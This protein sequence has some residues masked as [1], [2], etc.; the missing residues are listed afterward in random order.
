MHRS[1]SILAAILILALGC[2][3]SPTTE[4]T[5][6]DAGGLA[7]FLSAEEKRYSQLDEEL[8]IRYFF[9]DRRDGFFLDVGSAWA[10][11][12]STT[13]YLEKHLGWTGVAIDALPEYRPAW[14]KT[15]PNAKFFSYA[16]SDTSGETVTFY[17]AYSP[18][19]SSLLS[20]SA[21]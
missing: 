13:Y 5:R 19:L 21:Y 7:T 1:G 15:R 6:T 14:E 16:V 17:R 18:A 12:Q 8:L 2:E 10:D 4:P 9:Q 20:C 11:R 3:E